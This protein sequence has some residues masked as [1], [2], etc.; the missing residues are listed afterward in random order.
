MMIGVIADTHGLLREEFIEAFGMCSIIFHAGDIGKEE[1]LHELEK[2]APVIAVRGNNDRGDWADKLPDE[3]RVEVNH[4]KI[5]MIHDLK[6][7]KAEFKKGEVDIVISGHSHIYKE[8]QKGHILYLNP[9]GAGAKRFGRPATVMI[10][11]ER[12]SVFQIKQLI[13]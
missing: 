11:E 6:A 2:I 9:G 10:I 3:V 8:E 12:S 5:Y 7:C 4:K 13:L 1:I